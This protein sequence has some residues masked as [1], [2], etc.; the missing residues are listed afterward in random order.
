MR[1]GVELRQRVRRAEVVVVQADRIRSGIQREVARFTFAFL[2]DHPELGRP[3]VARD[4][5]EL[6]DREEEQIGAHFRRGGEQHARPVG[7][8]VRALGHR[9]V[10]HGGEIPGNRQLDFEHRLE[11]GLIPHR[12]EAARGAD[13]A[14]VREQHLLAHALRRRIADAEDATHAVVDRAGVFHDDAVHADDKRFGEFEDHPL[15]GSIADDPGLGTLD[16]AC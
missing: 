5:V 15:A 11:I 8:H 10:G 7:T 4:A 6:A 13:T 1:D 3:D 14:K 9:H 12:R 2:Q 16:E